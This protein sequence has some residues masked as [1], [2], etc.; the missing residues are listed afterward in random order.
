MV[1][2]AAHIAP[3][4]TLAAIDYHTMLSQ[5]GYVKL[6]KAIMRHVLWSKDPLVHM[7]LRCTAPASYQACMGSV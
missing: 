3:V 7:W 1:V 4:I 5:N 6:G 2:A